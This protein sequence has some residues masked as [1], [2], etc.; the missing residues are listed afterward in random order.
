MDTAVSISSTFKQTMRREFEPPGRTMI[1]LCRPSGVRTE[2][3]R[4]RFLYRGP[5][6]Y[7]ALPVDV[8]TMSIEC[9]SRSL[10]R[11]RNTEYLMRNY[12]CHYHYIVLGSFFIMLLLEYMCDVC[13]ECVKVSLRRV[14]YLF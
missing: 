7:N 3:G 14:L 11:M 12:I 9:F 1:C 8:R 6:W 10:K 2:A 13:A 4:R 5:V